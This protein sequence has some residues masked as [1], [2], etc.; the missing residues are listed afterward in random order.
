VAID[1]WTLGNVREQHVEPYC[2]VIWNP[3]RHIYEAHESGRNASPPL[4]TLTQTV[5][6]FAAIWSLCELPFELLFT[7]T[8]LEGATCIAGKLLWLS[9]GLWVLSGARFARFIFA[10]FCAASVMAIAPGLLDDRRFSTGL[11][12]VL[13]IECALKVAAFSCIVFASRRT[14]K[15]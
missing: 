13:I 8:I 1:Q 3:R 5:V 14:A 12:C 10:F 7:P 15:R 4:G 6:V 9:L 11:T 2:S